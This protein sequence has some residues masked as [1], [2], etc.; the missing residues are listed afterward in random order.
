MSFG[1]TRLRYN[2]NIYFRSKTVCKYYA[3][4]ICYLDNLSR[5]YNENK[6]KTKQ[7]IKCKYRKSIPTV[8]ETTRINFDY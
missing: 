8:Q 2:I 1:L 7:T 4:S 3:V 5:H 6:L